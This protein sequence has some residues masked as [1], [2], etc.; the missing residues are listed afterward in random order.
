VLTDRIAF[1]IS[2]EAKIEGHSRWISDYELMILARVL[3]VPLDTLLPA[4]RQMSD[5][6]REFM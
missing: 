3:G 2:T 1:A 4:T 6:L 5:A